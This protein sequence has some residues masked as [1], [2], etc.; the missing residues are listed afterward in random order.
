ML[1][2][3]SGRSRAMPVT[4]I[5]RIFFAVGAFLVCSQSSIQADTLTGRVLDPQGRVVGNAN[6][7]LY[8][9]NNGQQRATMSSKDGVFTFEEIPAGSY[10]LEADASDA[11]L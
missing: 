4:L 1:S 5:K 6:V 9:R 2:A 8:D 7:R 11:A 10:L 3:L